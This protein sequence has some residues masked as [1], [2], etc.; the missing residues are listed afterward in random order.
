MYLSKNN[1]HKLNLLALTISFSGNIF[2]SELSLINNN[3]VSLKQ[4]T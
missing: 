2:A 1:N 3:S 4:P